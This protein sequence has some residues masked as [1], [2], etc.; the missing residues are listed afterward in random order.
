VHISNIYK[1]EPF[2]HVSFIAPVCKGQ[3]CGFGSYSYI[4]GVR[5]LLDVLAE[6][7]LA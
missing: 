7:W 4:L 5:A 1:R 3:I 2:R 6:E